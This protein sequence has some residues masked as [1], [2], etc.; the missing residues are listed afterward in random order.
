MADGYR[1]DDMDVALQAPGTEI[2]RA[3]NDGLAQCL[4]RLDAGVRTDPLFAG[5]P[6]DRC[7]CV[8][9]G[10][11]IDGT[12]RVHYADGSKDYDGGEVF[13]WAAGHNL[14]AVTDAVYLEISPSTDYDALMDHCRAVLGG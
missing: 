3:D 8:H 13:Y 2:R 14:E 10:Y 9:W 5:L 6:E 1:W 4:I 7:Q 11:I 12:M